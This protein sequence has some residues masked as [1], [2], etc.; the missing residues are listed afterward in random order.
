M[1]RRLLSAALAAT[2]VTFTVP[3]AQ[4]QDRRAADLEWSWDL[5]PGATLEVRGING[6]ITVRGASGRRARLTAEKTAGRRC[7][8]DEVRIEVSEDRR[9]VVVCALYPS[10]RGENV[11]ERDHLESSNDNC[12]VEVE[13]VVEVPAGVRFVGRTVNGGV[14]ATD[15][16]A[17]LELHTVNGSIRLDTS[18]W[19]TARTVNGTI[20][21]SIGIAS[22]DEPVE[23][24]TVNGN[25]E[26][27]L[28]A[29][30]AADLHGTFLN[31]SVQSDFP[32]SVRGKH[33]PRR[34]SG[35][36]GRGGSTLDLATLNGNLVLRTAR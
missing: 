14:L 28:P 9:G 2:A 7:D 3:A 12:D 27:E 26:V 21:A 11:C 25:I 18:E 16:A 17:P 15:L 19:A 22:W 8:P 6:G 31:G 5:A 33:G 20:H 36:L 34:V 1:L 13:F 24:E 29:D 10:R 30:V 35:T 32:V 23:L 4:T